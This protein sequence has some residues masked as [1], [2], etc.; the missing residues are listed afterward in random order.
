MTVFAALQRSAFHIEKFSSRD[1][2]AAQGRRTGCAVTAAS[3]GRARPGV[4]FR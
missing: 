2:E 3:V 4:V 1:A